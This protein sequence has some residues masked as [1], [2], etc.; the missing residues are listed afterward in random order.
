MPGQWRTRV[1]EFM[2]EP[3]D[4]IGDP[5]VHRVVLQAAAQCAKTEVLL[6]TTGF[7]IHHD[8][9]PI[10]VVQPTL[11]MAKA[12]SK[13]RIAPMVRDTRVLAKLVSEGKARDKDNTIF[14]KTFPGGHLT[15]VGA[16]SPASLASRP[17][18]AVLCDE[19]DRFPLSA[20]AE[21]D[22]IGLAVKRTV[23]FWN[24]V[25]VF[26]ST[27][28]VK[29]ASRIEAAFNEGDQRRHW[30]A[31]P[32]CDEMQILKW[33]NV[34]WDKGEP[35]TA[36]YY[37]DFCGAGWT[38]AQRIAAVRKGEWRATQPFNGIASFH[39]TGMMSPFVML[40]EA[41]REFLEAKGDPARLKV[42]VNTYLGETWEETGDRIDSHEL[43]ERQ[44]E[45]ATEIPE[46]VTVLTAGIDVQDDRLEMEVVGWGDDATSWSINH[47]VIYG[48]P[49]GTQLWDE[50][51]DRLKQVYE[52]PMFGDVSVQRACIDSG[53]HFTQ[54]VYRYVRGKQ[55]L[56]FAIKG[57]AGI[58]R[59]IVGKPSMS[60]VGRIPLVPVG[61]HTAKELVVRRLAAKPGEAGRCHFP[62]TYQHEYFAQMTAEE[63]VTRYQKG[64]KKQEFVVKRRRNE[65]FDCRVYATAA[66]EMTGVN[67]NA[68]RRQ[69]EI[70]LDRSRREAEEKTDTKVTKPAKVS[71]NSGFVNSWRDQ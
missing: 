48:D 64:F 54:Q 52:H 30:C 18:R 37:C 61:V 15:M 10:M 71:R 35:D 8:P 27:P 26:V 49:S 24:R 44:E 4:C 2:R 1:V 31:C 16:N 47:Y 9:S 68:H 65:V 33:A 45:Y 25:V 11:D 28:T 69:L 19:V 56:V 58:G 63:L 43:M 29:G 57:V 34:K 51:D 20:G 46:E 53:G 5:R 32:H 59:P 42:W 12:F 55:P 6:N 62:A 23:T 67:L 3:M 41:V 66:L 7:L 21:G 70:R 13:D 60:N 50:L 39:I 17:I 14:Q 22:P 36:M 38:D 40:S